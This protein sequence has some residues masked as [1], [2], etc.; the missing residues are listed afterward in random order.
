MCCL[1]LE[2]GNMSLSYSDRPES[3][4]P[5]YKTTHQ[6]SAWAASPAEADLLE[7]NARNQITLWG[8]TGCVSVEK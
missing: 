3:L 4:M 5:I 2:G 7:F 1:F 8:P 6:P